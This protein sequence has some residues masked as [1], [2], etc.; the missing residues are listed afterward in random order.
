MVILEGKVAFVTGGGRGIGQA[1]AMA[2]G[3]AG[4]H[5]AVS[6]RTV[7]QIN[8]TATM[9][10]DAGGKAIAVQTDVSDATSVE[11]AVS[12]TKDEIGPVDILVNNAGVVG[13]ALALWETDPDEWWQAQEINLRG[14]YLCSRAVIPEMI[15]RNSGRIINVSSGNAYT[16]HPY[17]SAYGASKAGVT[18]FSNTLARELSAYAIPVFAY[19]PGLVQTEML[20]YAAYSQQVDERLREFFRTRAESGNMTPMASTVAT[21]MQLVSGE[22]DVLSG[23]HVHVDD[24]LD[25]MKSSVGNSNPDR[26]YMLTRKEPPS[27]A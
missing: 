26:L 15:T 2:L 13:H 24:D 9:I 10:R 14:T 18:H 17:A 12:L 23:C 8:E 21:F 5:V 19:A 6:A 22:F 3:D 11:N 20:E 25:Q 4:V 1:L 16:S 7:D 27:D